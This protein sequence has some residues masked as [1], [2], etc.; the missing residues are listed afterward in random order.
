MCMSLGARVRLTHEESY[1]TASVSSS[2]NTTPRNRVLKKVIPA[3]AG[4]RPI[5]VE[6]C[7][8]SLAASPLADHSGHRCVATRFGVVGRRGVRLGRRRG[9]RVLS[10][11]RVGVL[12][13]RLRRSG[14]LRLRRLRVDPRLRRRLLHLGRRDVVSRSLVLVGATAN[15]RVAPR[16]GIV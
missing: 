10:G 1:S 14:R 15:R 6:S 5:E 9:L 11:P 2:W 8:R 7:A 13:R 16:T 3:E 12:L 4:A